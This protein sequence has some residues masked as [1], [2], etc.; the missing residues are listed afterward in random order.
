MGLGT[1]HDATDELLLVTDGTGTTH[2]LPQQLRGTAERILGL[3]PASVAAR[4]RADR[5]ATTT[6][7]RRELL[8][9]RGTQP[10]GQLRAVHAALLHRARPD[11]YPAP[12]AAAARPWLDHC[13]L[14]EI[15]R[16][17]LTLAGDLDAEAGAADGD[18][19]SA[20]IPCGRSRLALAWLLDG[21]G[22]YGFKPLTR[23]A[24]FHD[25]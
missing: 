2:V 10:A 1:I 24:G 12:T 8:R 14:V 16:D 23:Q 19:V 4:D 15:A 9:E 7:R 3:D 5:R 6:V 20:A 13:P 21:Q 17:L 22:R 25:A 11:R 18:G